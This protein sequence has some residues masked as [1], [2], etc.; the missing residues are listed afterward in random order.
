M[1]LVL[2]DSGHRLVALT[3]DQPA[4]GLYRGNVGTVV[5]IYHTNNLCEVKFMNRTGQW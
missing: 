5:H 3:A 1:I 4:P 2:D